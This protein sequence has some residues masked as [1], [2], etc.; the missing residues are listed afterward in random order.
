M[1]STP[2]DELFG[3]APSGDEPERTTGTGGWIY[4]GLL[5]VVF[6]VMAWVAYG[7]ERQPL[8]G[9]ETVT[10]ATE[11][12]ELV[13]R[14]SGERATLDGRVP[15]AEVEQQLLELG[16]AR[17][18]DD[19]I[20]DG[21]VVDDGTTLE[22]GTVSVV[23]SAVEGD[24]SPTALQADIVAALELRVGRVELT[25][26]PAEEPTEPPA[27]PEPVQLAVTLA[28]DRAVVAGTLPDEAA[29]EQ[30]LRSVEGV[31]GTPEASSLAAGPATWVGGAVTISGSVDAGDTRPARLVEALRALAPPEVPVDASAVVVDTSP[32]A[33]RRLQERLR[34]QLRA[35]PVRFVGGGAEIDP[36]SEAVL[37]D[38]AAVLQAAPGV[39]A[40]IV[41]F[42]DPA[43]DPTQH[44]ALSE[45]RARTV[46]DRLVSLGVDA[47]RLVPV[48]LG[49]GE[50]IAA[51]DTE[52][53]RAANRR[54]EVRFPASS[55]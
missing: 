45:A 10:G 26:V 11:P 16:R 51:S 48:W 12:V 55:G 9:V 15:N 28:P 22:A 7:C 21:L 38:L 34:D 46:V 24:P 44:V 54:I 27:P 40:E 20:D 18:G 39:Q 4:L 8:A 50:P 1:R 3:E 32:E 25:L 31:W 36:A 19:R 14:I 53:G 33:L 5:S 47:G 13:L 49:A 6:V 43:D 17:Y 30:V 42:S 37:A 41:G 29:A 2:V 52:E 35:Q 23:G